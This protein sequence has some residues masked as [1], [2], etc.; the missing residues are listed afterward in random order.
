MKRRASMHRSMAE[1]TAFGT[2]AAT[3]TRVAAL[4]V[5]LVAAIGCAADADDT[6]P[7]ANAAGSAGAGS[8]LPDAQTDAGLQ[9]SLQDSKPHQPVDCYEGAPSS[10]AAIADG[11][12]VQQA[13]QVTGA[14][15][16]SKKFLAS[17]SN[18]SNKCLW[19][20]YVM[21]PAAARGVQLISE[22]GTASSKAQC[23]PSGGIP[24]EIK[25]GDIVSFVGMT[26]EFG[27]TG[28]C[29][30]TPAKVRQVKICSVTI[31]GNGEPPAPVLVAD[32]ADLTKGLKQ[33]QNL[34]VKIENVEVKLQ[35]GKVTDKY[36]TM[37]L[38]GSGLLVRDNLYYEQSGAPKFDSTTTKFNSIVGISQLNY[39]DWVLQPRDKCND[40]DPK[41][42]D[43][44]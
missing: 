43:C 15:V 7:G 20:V 36:G 4:L 14:I 25:P 33:Y 26:S 5:L 22:E 44:P 1:A 34:L 6:R 8:D 28:N 40:I 35:D 13:V 27:S 21:D 24:N 42:S 12:D 32:P 11:T 39:C 41:S 18:K 30:T 16:T 29:S 9:D 17:F 10:I 38:Q 2:T 19:S 23:D 37:V 3:T 31:T